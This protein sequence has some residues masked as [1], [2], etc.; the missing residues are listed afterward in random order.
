M[1]ND[2]SDILESPWES[3][4][5]LLDVIRKDGIEDE[6]VEKAVIAAVRLLKGVEDEFSPELIAKVGAALYPLRNG[7][8]NTGPGVPSPGGLFGVSGSDEED[9]PDGSGSGADTDVSVSGASLEGSASGAKVAADADGDTE[10]PDD[11]AD[12][13]KKKKMKKADFSASSRRDLAGQGKALPDGS[14]PIRNTKDLSNAIHDV[15]RAK[16]PGRAKSWIVRRARALG[17]T[18][19]LPDSWKVSKEDLVV[20]LPEDAYLEKSAD[21]VID[22]ERGTVETHAVPVQKEDGSWDFT[23][24][25]DASAAFFRAMIQKQDEQAVELAAAK[26]AVSKADDT[27]LSRQMVEKAA[28][29]N[30]VAATD[31]LAPILKEASLKLDS[32]SFEKLTT[33]LEAAQERISKGDLFSE[34]GSRSFGNDSSK[35]DAD[36]QLIAK[37]KELVEKGGDITFEAAYAKAMEQN[38]DLYAQYTFEKGWGV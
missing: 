11:D 36:S 9:P 37:A 1:E 35:T 21:F 16:D 6:T 14:F 24:V 4:G 22:D 10:E 15:G 26:E 30:H 23:D 12:D 5:A 28:R 19:M 7:P 3:E 18:G 29:L 31:D 17:A 34:M 8:L 38:P 33:V 27:L 25:P 32:E 13:G 2:L 20:D